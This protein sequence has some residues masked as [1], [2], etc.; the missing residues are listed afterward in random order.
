M[1]TREQITLADVVPAPGPETTR[2]LLALLGH[3][4][5]TAGGSDSAAAVEHLTA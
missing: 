5:T 4:R 3:V 1:E 2:R